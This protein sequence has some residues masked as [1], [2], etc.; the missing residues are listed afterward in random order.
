[1]DSDLISVKDQCVSYLVRIEDF[2]SPSMV[3]NFQGKMGGN[4]SVAK[5]SESR[6]LREQDMTELVRRA[7]NSLLGGEPV[8]AAYGSRLKPLQEE[9]GRRTDS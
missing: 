1:M 3:Y 9:T 5:R 4:M 2:C 7:S 6:L 8:D